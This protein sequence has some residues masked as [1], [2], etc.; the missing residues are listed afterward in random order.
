MKRI[1]LV[2]CLVEKRLLLAVAKTL[3]EASGCDVRVSLMESLPFDPSDRSA[4][5]SYF[6]KVFYP[7]MLALVV[8]LPVRESLVSDFL[9]LVGTDRERGQERRYFQ[10][11]CK[12]AESLVK[13]FQ[14]RK[15]V[16]YGGYNLRR[17]SSASEG[18]DK[19]L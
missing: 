12:E 8:L 2:G 7:D 15:E 17:S 13:Y 6:A 11:V 1:Y 10:E 14:N 5:L 19:G 16:Y 9:I 18:T 4:L 3:K